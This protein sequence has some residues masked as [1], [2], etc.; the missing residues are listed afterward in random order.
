MITLHLCYTRKPCAACLHEGSCCRCFVVTL[1]S[2]LLFYN[3]N[4]VYMFC[5]Y[6]KW[7]SPS[8]AYLHNGDVH[9][10]SAASL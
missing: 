9:D 6:A 10:T 5:L 3:M 2:Y 7:H 1:F 4:A 8:V